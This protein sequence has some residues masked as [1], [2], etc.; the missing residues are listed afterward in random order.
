MMPL[1]RTSACATVFSRSALA[2]THCSRRCARGGWHKTSV[3]LEHSNGSEVQ[4]EE[5]QMIELVRAMTPEE[6]NTYIEI[7]DATET[8]DFGSSVILKK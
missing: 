6:R 5:N 4:D 8:A 3:E 7:L 2:L 1:C